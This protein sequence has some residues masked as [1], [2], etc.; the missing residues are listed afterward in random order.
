MYTCVFQVWTSQL[1]RAV[2]TAQFLEGVTV[3]RW[4]ALNEMDHVSYN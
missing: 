4:K 3:E 1:K 2:D